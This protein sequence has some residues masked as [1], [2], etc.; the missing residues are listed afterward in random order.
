[1]AAVTIGLAV[2]TAAAPVGF[3][4]VAGVAFCVAVWTWPAVTLECAVIL[5]LVV[6]PWVDIFSERR[7]GLSLYVPNPAVLVGLFVLG[8]VTVQMLRR[9]RVGAPLW[10][11]RSFASAHVLLALAYGVAVIADIRLYGTHGLGQGFREVVRV[12]SV[13]GA[14]L[15]VWWWADGDPHRY[16]RGW[17]YLWVGL[18]VPIAVA[19]W[20][21]ATGTGFLETAGLNR[22]E[23]T[24][25]HPN[26]FG[27][28]LVPFVLLCLSAAAVRAGS[29]RLLLLLVA[30]GLTWLILMTY[31]RT[32]V[33]VLAIGLLVLPFL[34][35]RRLGGRALARALG[36]VAVLAVAGWLLGGDFIRERFANMSLGRGALD[37]A[38]SGASENS[39]EWRLINWS[40]LIGMGMDHPWMGHGAGMTSVLNPIV[41]L[42]NGVPYNAHNDFVRFFFEGGSLGVVAYLFY[43]ICLC[44]WVVRRARRASTAHAATAFSVAAA[45]LALVLLS[46][47]NT[48]LSLHTANLYT[49]Y[50]M[51]ALVASTGGSQ[52]AGLLARERGIA[53]NQ[54]PP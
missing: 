47:G 44:R 26:S 48:E 6:R 25:S 33:L 17:A 30:T 11:D 5:A 8:V 51:L 54:P 1:V 43:A 49:L 23:G 31:S 50:G 40:V 52:I 39:Y 3:A 34:H 45:C 21:Y 32:V 41:N 29:R 36:V 42:N 27:Q 37:A 18:S 13:V 12:A 16:R 2:A 14:F 53:A 20:Q 7:V 9:G 24:L 38:L 28:Y 46:A 15:V 35:V 4:I 22:L 10:P 19:L